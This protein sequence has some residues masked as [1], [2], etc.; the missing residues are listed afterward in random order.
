[1]TKKTECPHQ[2]ALAAALAHQHQ[3]EETMAAQSKTIHEQENIIKNLRTQLKWKEEHREEDYKLIKSQQAA[4]RKTER[5]K[6]RLQQLLEIQQKL[7][8]EKRES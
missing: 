7:L 8:R 2:I 1:V 6:T 5:E 4:I 3:L